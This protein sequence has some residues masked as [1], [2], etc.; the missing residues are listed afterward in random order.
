MPNDT[1]C[2]HTKESTVSNS[3]C[4]SERALLLYKGLNNGRMEQRQEI[5]EGGSHVAN[6]GR[7]QSQSP[8]V[9]TGVRL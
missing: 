6:E 3:K 8:L 5:R 4:G 1:R 2:Y 9:S 7:G